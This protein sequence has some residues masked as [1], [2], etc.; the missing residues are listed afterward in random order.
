VSAFVIWAVVALSATFWAMRLLVRSPTTPPH[1]AP[2]GQTMAARGDVSRLFGTTTTAS[3][4]AAAP[5]VSS[6]FRLVG[7]AAPKPGSAASGGVAL[8]AIDGKPPRPYRVGSA[9]EGDLTLRAVDMRTASLGPRHGADTVILEIAPRP[10]AATGTLP[11][12][13]PF[14]AAAPPST[15]A[16]A[17]GAAA[18]PQGMPQPGGAPARLRPTVVPGTQGL[19]PQPVEGASAVR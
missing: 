1:A 4:P 8:I 7:V 2:A 6:R 11:P 14:G 17:T 15:I 9:V 3:T 10:V 16:P 12:A 18:L 19:A 5:A 13:P